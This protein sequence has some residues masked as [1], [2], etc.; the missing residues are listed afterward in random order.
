MGY[1]TSANSG[2]GPPTAP[3]TDLTGLAIPPREHGMI[4]G[5]SFFWCSSLIRRR[6]TCTGN[7]RKAKST[8]RRL[9]RKLSRKLRHLYVR[10]PAQRKCEPAKDAKDARISGGESSNRTAV[11]WQQSCWKPTQNGMVVSCIIL[12]LAFLLTLIKSRISQSG[13][14]CTRQHNS[15]GRC[16]Q[17]KLMQGET[18][19][20]TSRRRE[21]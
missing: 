3:A 2:A 18:A 4:Y 20:A 11:S 14:N 17:E 8:W 7:C 15:V 16:P 19:M 5:S 21:N 1:L 12:G 10:H 13:T 9:S 6:N